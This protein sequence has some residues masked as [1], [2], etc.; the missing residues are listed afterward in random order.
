MKW[1]DGSI[2]I[3][4]EEVP[5][6]T[7]M[8]KHVDLKYFADNPRIYS[9]VRAD[10]AVPDQDE[11]QKRLWKMDHV[12]ELR[13]DIKE[14]GGLI[15]PIIVKSGTLEV[16]EG[17][18]RLAAY[19][20]LAESDPITWGKIKCTLLPQ[21]IEESKVFS[22]LGQYHIKGK[23]DWSPY[24]QAG[25]LYRRHKQHR[26]SV[27]D[28]GRDLGIGPKEA[29]KLIRVYQLMVDNR[30]NDTNRWSYYYEYLSSNKLKKIREEYAGFDDVVFEKI[31]SGEIVRAADIRDKLSKIPI[32]KRKII[33]DFISG[34]LTIDEAYDRV[35]AS[36]SIDLMYNKI[37]KFRVWFSSNET[38]S[39]LKHITPQ[40]RLKI[41]F[42]IGKLAKDT[43]RLK[44]ILENKN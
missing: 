7:G 16:L 9:V 10:G 34:G 22:L 29:G 28:L 17:N 41:S 19:R 15:D 24:E 14:N 3:R 27:T 31:K 40:A 5:V 32:T 13:I 4:G 21:E 37:N 44:G 26:I 39:S 23:K 38:E 18:S 1:E 42:E 43:K 25:F 2:M 6:K 35:E 11:I 20:K 12:K 30:D 36:G 33:R 8:I